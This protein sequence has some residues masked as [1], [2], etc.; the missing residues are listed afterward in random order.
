MSGRYLLDTAVIIALLANDARVVERIEDAAEVFVPSIVV[1][2]LFYG[3]RR[4]S[5]P[6]E[7][8][9]WV[10]ELVQESTILA[11]D[12]ETSRWYGV[13]KDLL[14]Q[15]NSPCPENDLW[16]AALALQ[17]GLTLVTRDVHFSEVTNLRIEFW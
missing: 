16:I 3:A 9:A 11:C 7:N 13:V 6:K 1:G 5:R 14:R 2:E 12:T 15:K 8:L 10:N 4:S 17:Y